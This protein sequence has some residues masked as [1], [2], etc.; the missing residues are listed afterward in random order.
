MPVSIAL[1]VCCDAGARS[2]VQASRAF[3][4]VLVGDGGV[5]KTTFVK[6]H[7]SGDFETK[8]APTLG[9]VVRRC[10][11]CVVCAA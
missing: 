5:G 7:V 6:R 2:F 11:C 1:A 4:V 8:Y 10:C 9:A 3:K